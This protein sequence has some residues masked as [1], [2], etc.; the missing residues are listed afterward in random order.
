MTLK[1]FSILP[2]LLAVFLLA[3]CSNKE[4]SPITSLDESTPS[5]KFNLDYWT[6]QEQSNSATWKKAMTICKGRNIG[7]YP[8][9]QYV[10]NLEWVYNMAHTNTTY[11]KYNNQAGF[12]KM[13]SFS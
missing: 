4:D 11:P 10:N 8:N 1:S 12:G 9:C 7:Q 13:P 6:A 2:V 5:Q 3:G